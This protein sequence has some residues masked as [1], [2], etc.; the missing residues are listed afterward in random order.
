MTVATVDIINRGLQ[1][2]GKSRIYSTRDLSALAAETGFS[3]DFVRRAELRRNVWRFSIRSAALRAADGYLQ[4][5]TFATW[6]IGTTY[7]KNDIVTGSDGQI[8]ISLVAS[9]LGNDPTTTSGSWALYCGPVTAIP[10]PSVWS[11]SPTYVAN[12]VVT[13]SDGNYYIALSSNQ[14]HDPTTDNGVHWEKLSA[15]TATGI[16]P[17][18]ADSGLSFYSGEIVFAAGNV[19]FSLVSSNT[20]DPTTDLTGSWF[21][22][23]A[24]PTLSKL[25]FIYPI[26]SGPASDSTTRNAFLLPNGF[27]CEAPQDPKAGRFAP[28]GAPQNRLFVDWNY[29]NDCFTS[30]SSGPIVFRFAADISD[31]TQFDP[32]FIEGLACRVAMEMCESL[33]GSTEKLA[34]IGR[35]Y[36][37]FMGEARIRNGIE[38]GA[39]D[40]PLDLLLAV[41][42]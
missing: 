7:S 17:A 37:K 31:P 3:Y 29:E 24:V 33:T 27:M 16:L 39:I 36:E 6:A 12:S 34:V 14:N 20:T 25:S 38:T 21:T 35:E 11:S 2:L 26:G 5:V 15:S 32:M 28:L 4:S 41:R 30:I 40:P 9:N 18:F 22:L 19:Y 42:Y 10:F 13:G 23:T 8:Y 1:K